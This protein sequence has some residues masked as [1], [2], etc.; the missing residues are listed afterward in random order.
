MKRLTLT[1]LVAGQLTIAAQ[2]GFAA[3]LTEARTQQAGGFAGL[4]LRMPLDGRAGDRQVRAGLTLAPVLQAR[5][6]AGETHT[7]M[8]E[9]L[10]L[11]FVGREPA[12]FSVAG[13]PISRLAEGPVGPDGRR[14]GVSTVGW[15]AI[16]V[17]AAVLLTVGFG[18]FVHRNADDRRPGVG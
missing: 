2:P 13:T 9:G 1:A 14:L 4:R 18:Y 11:G 15:I 6:L 5:T 3:D 12:S 16:G 10:E 17:G 7:R 8:G